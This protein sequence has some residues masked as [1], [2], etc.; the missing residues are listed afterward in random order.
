MRIWHKTASFGS[1]IWMHFKSNYK[2]LSSEVQLNELHGDGWTQWCSGKGACWSRG[3]ALLE[4][5]CWRCQ[6][7]HRLD[8]VWIFPLQN[9]NFMYVSNT[10][11]SLWLG[12]DVK[13]KVSCASCYNHHPHNHPAI[14]SKVNPS[15]MVLL[16]L[17]KNEDS[18]LHYSQKS[19]GH[20][21]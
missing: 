21:G 5:Q 3:K 12:S 7:Q 6:I 1:S 15:R 14:V 10:G 8:P 19:G 17:S 9:Q 18:C 20:D 11:P 13:L 4:V 2:P 16:L